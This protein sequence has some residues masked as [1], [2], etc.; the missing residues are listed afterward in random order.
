MATKVQWDFESIIFTIYG[1]SVVRRKQTDQKTAVVY[2]HTDDSLQA[3]TTQT[4]TPPYTRDMIKLQ[5]DN[6]TEAVLA[7]I[8]QRDEIF[9]FLRINKYSIQSRNSFTDRQQLY[10]EP[11]RFYCCLHSVPLLPPTPETPTVT[12]HQVH[13]HRNR[14]QLQL[15]RLK[16]CL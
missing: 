12:L 6:E 8:R 16:C 11:Q 14:L 10:K 15:R 13:Q 7:T 4:K 5:S 1:G 3:E 9:R 2:I